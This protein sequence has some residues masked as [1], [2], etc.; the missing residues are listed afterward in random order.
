[1]S[2]LTAKNYLS[3]LRHFLGW[4]MF[5]LKAS[6]EH[7]QFVD[8]DDLPKLI[9]E[10]LNWKIVESY[11]KYLQDNQIP[12]KTA[13]RRLS[14]LRKFCSFCISQDWLKE[15]PAKQTKNLRHPR[16]S[17]DLQV[18]NEFKGA[19]GQEVS[20]DLE[21]FLRLSVIS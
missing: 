1:M 8:K 6:P 16:E 3:D 14:T 20:D 4:L 19:F 13:N 9:N 2:L 17:E 7:A 12:I 15:N 18:L 10:F 11:K 5:T 21:E